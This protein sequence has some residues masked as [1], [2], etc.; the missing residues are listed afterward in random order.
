MLWRPK[1]L[2]TVLTPI[3]HIVK[4]HMAVARV[5]VKRTITQDEVD[6]FTQITGDTNPIHSRD[7]PADKRCVHGAFLNGIVAGIIGTQLPGPGSTLLHQEFGCPQKCVCD[8]EITIT[9]QQLDD[10]HVK[11]LTYEVKQLEQVVFTGTARIIVRKEKI[12]ETPT[13]GA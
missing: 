11:R 6:Q 13:P 5:V 4:R 7:F 1:V 3:E 8:E 9:V 10:R 12:T 2:R